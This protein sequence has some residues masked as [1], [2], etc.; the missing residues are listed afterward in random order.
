MPQIG[1]YR[2]S[3]RAKGEIPPTLIF[4]SQCRA[5]QNGNGFRYPGGFY[6]RHS[7]HQSIR[8]TQI[9]YYD[10][11]MNELPKDRRS[12]GKYYIIDCI[13]ERNRNGRNGVPFSAIFDIEEAKFDNTLMLI[14]SKKRFVQS[15]AWF[16]LEGK[17]FQG[18]PAFKKAVEEDNNLLEKLK[19]IGEE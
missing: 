7:W 6:L 19:L 11:K 14:E 17:K 13:V 5:E 10:S 15:G 12:E 1:M 4:I 8:L 18:L 2:N 16:E 3:L 9:K